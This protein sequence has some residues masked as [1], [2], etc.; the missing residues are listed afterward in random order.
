MPSASSCVLIPAKTEGPSDPGAGRGLREFRDAIGGVRA[1]DD[2]DALG[3]GRD[4][5][6][7]AT[8]SSASA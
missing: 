1:A 7:T 3:G 8:G 6:R 2:A 5:A 4:A